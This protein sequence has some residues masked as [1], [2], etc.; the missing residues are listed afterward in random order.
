MTH[1]QIFGFSLGLVSLVDSR[2]RAQAGWGR[3]LRCEAEESEPPSVRSAVPFLDDQVKPRGVP[4][5]EIHPFLGL[6]RLW[7]S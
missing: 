6:S 7:G 2:L 5:G 1:C 3:R 4:F